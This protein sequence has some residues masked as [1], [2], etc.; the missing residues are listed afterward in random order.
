MYLQGPLK[1]E[2]QELEELS[3]LRHKV[4]VLKGSL[5]MENKLARDYYNEL[6]AKVEEH[7]QLK[8]SYCKL[9]S[10]LECQQ[11]LSDN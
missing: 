1:F 8:K 2:S 6:C 7:E 4:R 5:D 10:K 11:Q 9:E 3:L